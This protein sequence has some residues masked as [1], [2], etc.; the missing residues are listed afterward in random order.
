VE[1]KQLKVEWGFDPQYSLFNARLQNVE[2]NENCDEI[3]NNEIAFTEYHLD[4]LRFIKEFKLQHT[5]SSL[6]IINEFFNDERSNALTHATSLSTATPN[7][8]A[9]QQPPQSGSSGWF[10]G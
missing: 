8:P 6:S 2:N 1:A 9:V 7:A 3:I 10:S 5:D 4:Y